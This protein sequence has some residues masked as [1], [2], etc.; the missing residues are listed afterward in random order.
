MTLLK[1]KVTNY[2]KR[3]CA[4]LLTFAILVT[5]APAPVMAQ[6]THK[7]YA[8]EELLGVMKDIVNWKKSAMGYS[9]EENLFQTS[10]VEGAG[11]TAA[12]WFPVG[13]GRS[14]YPDDYGAYLAVLGDQIT[15]RYTKAEKLDRSKATEWHRMS[16]AVLALGGDPTT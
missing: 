6:V 5:G 7:E 16:L 11:T 13:I 4:A 14:G 12:D 15:K 9:E 8:G 10:F 3:F 2:R 1:K